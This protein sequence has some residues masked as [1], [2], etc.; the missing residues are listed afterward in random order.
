MIA[1]L[2]KAGILPV[3]KD[4]FRIA[5]LIESN[6]SMHCFSN[7]VEMGSSAQDELDADSIV[8][9][10][11]SE[12]ANL[13]QSSFIPVSGAMS[14]SQLESDVTLILNLEFFSTHGHLNLQEA[15]STPMMPQ[16]ASQ[17][18]SLPTVEVH[19]DGVG[20][21]RALVDTGYTTTIGDPRILFNLFIYSICIAHYSQINICS[22]AH[23][24]NKIQYIN[25]KNNNKL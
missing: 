2:N 13:R 21:I 10:I 3:F 18:A 22:N 19:V 16:G 15:S 1:Y 23:T 5:L 12:V 6:S 14:R 20:M 4:V 17:F 8:P 25:I 7:Q 11:S 9:C 24:Y